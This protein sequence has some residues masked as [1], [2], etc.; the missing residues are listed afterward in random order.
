[1][2]ATPGEEVQITEQTNAVALS[3][4]AKFEPAG[5]A[6]LVT[7]ANKGLGREIARRLASLEMVVFA[8]SRD[9]QRGRAATNDLRAEGL[10][11]RY[12][13]LD[14]T[15]QGSIEAAAAVIDKEFGHL[16]VLVNNAGISLDRQRPPSEITVDVLR[17]TYE[18]NVF[19][20]AAVTL[21]MLPLLRR[22]SSARIVNMSSTQGSLSL[23]ADR[24]HPYGG[25]PNLLAYNSSKTALNAISLAFANELRGT[26]IK[27][28]SAS[29]GYVAT[30]LN[31][32]SGVM[33]VEQGARVPV[34]LA[35]LDDDGPS[36]A[37]IGENS[38]HGEPAS[39]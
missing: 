10:D 5:K 28:N 12:L 11:V 33:T 24:D 37:F 9:E 4:L 7:G 35:T 38:P 8:G 39:W 17:H 23:A 20:A 19:G 14:V 15:D 18:T 29:P 3:S 22:S 31:R 25:G 1:M 26:G 21:A 34:Y 6:A 13:H 27:V 2:D 32:R 36:G 30:D 16:D